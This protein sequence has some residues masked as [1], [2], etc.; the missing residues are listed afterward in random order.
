M[1]QNNVKSFDEKYQ[2]KDEISHV[3]D[4][5]GT[6]VGNINTEVIDYPLF[7]PSKNKIMQVPNTGYNA[8]LLKLVD[9]VLSNAVDEHRRKDSLFHI[10]KI[11]VEVNSDGYVCISDNGGIPV[12]IH[13]ETGLLIPELIFGQL[14]TGSNYDDT[15]QREGVGTNGLGA[16][17]T[18]IFS[19]NF[20]VTTSDSKN[21]V[22]IRW[23]NNMRDCNKNLEEYPDF[24]FHL[25]PANQT[26][27]SHGTTITFNLDLMRFDMEE[28]PM[29]IIRVIQKRCIDAA[30]TNPGLE[31]SFKTNIAEGKLDSIWQFNDFEEYV[32][33]YLTENQIKTMSSFQNKKDHII[34]VP[35]NIGFNFAFVNSGIC[36]E[37]SHIKKVQNQIVKTVLDFCSAQDMELITERDIINHISLFINTTIPNP[38]YDSQSKDKLASKISSHTLNLSKEF[39][40]T[41][42][43]SEIMLALTDFYKAKYEAVKKK[44]LRKLNAT[45]KTTKTKKLISCA[46]KDSNSNELWLFEGNSAS[47]GFRKSRNL[48]QAAY[49]LRGKIKNTFNLKKEQILDNLELREVIAALGILFDEPTKNVKNCKF[50]KIVIATDMD[51]DGNHIC[52]LLIAFLG[53]HFPELFKAGMIYRALSPIVIA[54]KGAGKSLQK[55]YYHTQEE[56]HKEEKLLKGWEVIYTKGLGGLSDSDYYHMVRQQKLI[57]FSMKSLYDYETISIW[58][59]KSTTQRKQIL[60]EDSGLIED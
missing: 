51:V 3:L 58:F 17:L 43:N 44:E 1:E 46:S 60:L 35:D 14:R 7:I 57:K 19:K 50:S 34:L 41:L 49:L 55:K 2:V 45:L 30:A 40:A 32:K 27:I 13:K 20:T 59:D 18:N 9:E 21:S 39:L 16:K 8:G 6:W 53:K 15:E 22:T 38:Q 26:S 36:S 42:K 10:D 12:V 29:S 24:G 28:I 37:G 33:L 25:I 23:E 4:R 5:P 47:N 11:S 56:Y 31:I 48:N 54:S 52:G